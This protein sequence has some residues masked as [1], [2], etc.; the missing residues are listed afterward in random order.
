MGLKY[1]KLQIKTV[2]NK[3]LKTRLWNK[4]VTGL[5]ATKFAPEIIDNYNI[6]CE[7]VTPK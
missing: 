6:D 4:H 1:R 2:Y 3:T 5:K 7:Y